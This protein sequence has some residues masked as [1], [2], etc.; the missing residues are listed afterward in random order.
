MSVC[1]QDA[2]VKGCR[3][4]ALIAVLHGAGLRRAEVV[5]LNLDDWNPEEGCLTV[6]SGKGDKD[7]TTSLNNG[8]VAALFDWLELGEIIQERCF[9]SP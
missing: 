5:A 7:R 9:T 1:C 6:R 2:S 3:D 4:A 8:A